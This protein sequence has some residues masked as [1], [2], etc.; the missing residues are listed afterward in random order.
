MNIRVLAPNRIQ[1]LS[2]REEEQVSLKD[3]FDQAGI[4]FTFSNLKNLASSDITYPQFLACVAQ[5]IL[6]KQYVAQTMDMNNFLCP[7]S[8]TSE[9]FDK[10]KASFRAGIDG[11]FLKKTTLS[12]INSQSSQNKV[13]KDEQEKAALEF[14]SWHDDFWFNRLKSQEFLR[15]L[16][17][18]FEGSE[19]PEIDSNGDDWMKLRQMYSKT[20]A[21]RF[22]EKIDLPES[23]FTSNA[24]GIQPEWC[25]NVLASTKLFMEMTGD[26]EMPKFESLVTDEDVLV[27]TTSAF[28]ASTL[29]GIQEIEEKK[30]RYSAPLDAYNMFNT[31]S[32]TGMQPLLK[33][34]QI[35]FTVYN[36]FKIL[37]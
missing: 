16:E 24:D 32:G 34:N 22:I 12:T 27:P 35:M 30:K 1:R 33:I 14:V 26:V 3:Q 6:L 19:M 25:K 8:R 28:V 23:L 37:L 31:F 15:E 10:Q 21:S 29:L 17:Q 4:K 7:M 18:V 36:Y 20:D 5:R 13:T 11:L 9:I 2:E